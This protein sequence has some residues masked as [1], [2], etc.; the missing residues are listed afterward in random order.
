M[1]A[2][3]GLAFL[4]VVVSGGLML[5][6]SALRRKAPPT[7]RIIP[8]FSR[9]RDAIGRA[10]E[11]GSRVHISLGRGGITTPQSGSVLAGLAMLR[12]MADLT[13]AGDKEPVAT[14]GD[15]AVTILSQGVLTSVSAELG[16]PMQAVGGRLTGLTPLSYVAGVLPLIQDEQVSTNV[17]IGNFGVEAGLLAEAADRS[18]AY[19]LAGSDSLPAQAILYASA[20]DPLIGE[21]LFAAPAYLNAGPMHLASL[22]VQDILRWAIVGILVIG[23]FVGLVGSL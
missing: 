9:L 19:S 4:V 11:E 8:A 21:E 15:A 20:Q 12:R 13:A 10:V 6:F 18:E 1:D 5:A 17:L 14:S 23:G 16:T 3:T 7:F 2:V 22:R